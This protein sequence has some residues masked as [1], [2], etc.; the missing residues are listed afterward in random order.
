MKKI[1]FLFFFLIFILHNFLHAQYCDTVSFQKILWNEG[2]HDATIKSMYF[3]DG[4]IYIIGSTESAKNHSNDIWVLKITQGG[5]VIW[6]KAVGLN[7][8]EN[9][10][11]VVQWSV[12][13]GPQYCSLSTVTQLNDNGYIAAGTLYTDFSGDSSGR[14]TAINKSTNIILRLDENGNIIWWKSFRYTASERLIR[15]ALLKDGSLFVTGLVNKTNDGYFI[16]LN[17]DNGK[18]LWMNEYKDLNNDISPRTINQA[19]N[20]IHLQIGNRLFFLTDDG[21]FFGARKIELNSTKFNL[22]DVPVGDLGS[23]SADE[24]LYD[25]NL[26]PS[27]S[28]ILFA[29]KNDSVVMW[30]HQYKQ[31]TNNLR[32]INN[33]IIHKNNVYIA[34]TY[35]A[36]NVSDNTPAENLSYFIKAYENGSTLCSDTFGI[37]FK[38]STIPFP[39]NITHG[40]INEGN[41]DA[42]FVYPYSENLTAKTQLDCD[43]QN[44]CKAVVKDTSVMLCSG[45]NYTLPPNDSLV[46]NTGI[47]SFHYLTTRGCDSTWNYNVKFKQPYSFNL[48]DTCLI[49]NEPVTFTLPFDSTAIYKWQDGSTLK[50]FTATMPGKYWVNVTTACNIFRDTVKVNALCSLPVYIPSGFTPNGD[51]KNDV[52]K[53]VN[54]SGQHMISL[55]VYNRYGQN[56]FSDENA[57]SG[58]NGTFN[59]INQP[60]GT[61]V[62]IFRYSDIEGKLHVLKGTVVL[63]R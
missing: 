39:P 18:I 47:Y 51:G 2:V 62:Y 12:M 10:N 8:D 58:W 17:Q 37:S 26:Y 63:I 21:K 38:V 6:S 53:A 48:S 19:N 50:N 55:S 7:A 9:I 1:S 4:G 11:G 3:T 61:Y 33:A 60:P 52:F 16:K 28:P 32:R 31:T 20:T 27:H 24:E 49:N 56:I 35:A 23:L 14:V 13:I 29:V 36:D 44:C 25:A 22:D 5:N 41:L 54:L 59:G 34:G 43:V 15:S 40:W 57:G 45:N 42:H 30:A 46:K